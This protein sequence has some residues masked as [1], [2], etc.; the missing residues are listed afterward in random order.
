MPL[1]K[2]DN[3]LF[4]LGAEGA[5]LMRGE[6][7][8]GM[9]DLDLILATFLTDSPQTSLALVLHIQ[10][11]LEPTL[12]DLTILPDFFRELQPERLEHKDRFL[13]ICHIINVKQ[14]G[15]A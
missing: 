15:E 6:V 11:H 8:L 14:A 12:T 4:L 3:G 2:G 10:Q 1:N 13:A 7:S 9:V 5:T